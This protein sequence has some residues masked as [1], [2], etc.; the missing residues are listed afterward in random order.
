V[1]LDNDFGIWT[2][3]GVIRAGDHCVLEFEIFH[4]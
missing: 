2:T 1:P 3:M 4:L